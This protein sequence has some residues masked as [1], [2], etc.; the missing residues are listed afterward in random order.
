MSVSRMF[1]SQMQAGYIVLM[2]ARPMKEGMSYLEAS[3]EA[4]AHMVGDL[5]ITCGVRRANV[6]VDDN[7]VSENEFQVVVISLRELPRCGQLDTINVM[8]CQGRDCDA[9]DCHR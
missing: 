1:N 5:V 7:R 6:I 3:D 8:S 4:V 9:E 2:V